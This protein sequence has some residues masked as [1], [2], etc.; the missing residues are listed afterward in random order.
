MPKHAIEATPALR[1][2]VNEMKRNA[3]ADLVGLVMRFNNDDSTLRDLWSEGS[4]RPK[5]KYNPHPADRPV[6]YR[7]NNDNSL[8]SGTRAVNKVNDI[9]G[10]HAEELFIVCWDALLRGAS[11]REDQ[12]RSVD[13]V[14][15]KSPCHGGTASSMLR[16]ADMPD[17][18]PI[19]C[20][21]KLHAFILAKDPRIEW[22][23]AFLALAGSDAPNYDPI[24]GDGVDRLMNARDR[25][26]ADAARQQAQYRT[27]TA[28]RRNVVS[29][30]ERRFA[31]QARADAQGLNG[32][33]RGLRIKEGGALDRTANTRDQQTRQQSN[34]LMRDARTT[35][36]A[37]AQAGIT[38]LERLINVDVRRWTE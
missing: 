33:A 2:A 23:I 21:S 37:T 25:Q 32:Q 38:L 3:T 18:M 14:L 17:F 20:S 30:L 28:P 29:E 26:L 27:Q 5:H 24:G 36:I 9:A 13:I 19:G 22:R 12:L 34:T 7:Y 16:T 10:F 4:N 31:Q 15:S 35:S 8:A 1:E 11:L 6:M